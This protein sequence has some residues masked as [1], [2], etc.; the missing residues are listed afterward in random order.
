[1]IRGVSG[2]RGERGGGVAGIPS[3]VSE[4]AVEANKSGGGTLIGPGELTVAQ[5]KL[6]EPQGVNRIVKKV[7]LGHGEVTVVSLKGV[8]N[9][10][11]ISSNKPGDIV[12]W[13]VKG[14]RFEERRFVRMLTWGVDVRETKL[15]PITIEGKIDRKSVTGGAR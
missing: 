9:E 11:K 7:N 10:I 8:A 15:A 2:Y 5:G 14:K 3:M 6:D 13:I 4:D 12:T 1:M